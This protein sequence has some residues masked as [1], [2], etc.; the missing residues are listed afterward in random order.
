MNVQRIPERLQKRANRLWIWAVITQPVFSLAFWHHQP[1][2]ALN[3]LFVFAGVT[4]LIALQYQHGLK[5]MLAGYLLLALMIWP[6]QPASY[7]LAGI[8]L[9]ISMATV[10]G[11]ENPKCSVG[12]HHCRAVTD[13]FKRVIASPGYARRNIITGHAAYSGIPLAVVSFCRQ[14]CP[15]GRRRFMPRNFFYY[16]YAGHLGIIGLVQST[17][18]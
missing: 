1:W 17:F 15:E 5:G 3:I 13:L 16:A 7:G 4:Q 2:W 12:G 10:S 18:G 9:A 14:I 8:T 11:N 6:L